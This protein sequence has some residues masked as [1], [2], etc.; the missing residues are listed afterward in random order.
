MVAD[1]I[2]HALQS[3]FDELCMVCFS[4]SLNVLSLCKRLCYLECDILLVFK[5]ASE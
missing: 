1:S 5:K 2:S 3:I 4:V